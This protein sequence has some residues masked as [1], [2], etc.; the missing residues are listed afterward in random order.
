[1]LKIKHY[2]FAFFVFLLLVFLSNSSFVFALETIY[3]DLTFLNL[4]LITDSSPI[5]HYVSYFFGLG[6]IAAVI[7]ALISMTIGFIQM[8]YPSPET[9][10]DA[11]DRVK[12]SVLGLVLT[13]SAFIILRTINLSLVAPTT[14]PLTAGAGIFYTNGQDLKPAAPS[15]NTS[16]I[17]PGFTNIT[18]R[19]NSG[20]ALLIW[21]FPQ[22]NL[23]GYENTVVD[24]ITCGNTSSLN[25]VASFKVAYEK[26]GIYYC[27]GGC[28]GDFCKGYM[29]QENLV[30]GELPEP[31]KNNI[32]SVLFVN[33]LSK[34]IIYSAI[35]HQQN[36]PT[37]GGICSVPM[38]A[39]KERVCIN[40]SKK[41]D[42][43]TPENENFP[44]SSVSIYQ[45][46]FKTPESS[47]DGIEFYSE[48][49]GWNSGAKAGKNFINKSV[50][51]NFWNSWTINLF[52]NYDNVDRP[53][54]Y[55]KSYTNFRE[56]SGSIRVKGSYVVA[57]YSE[58][59]SYCQVF[60]A[61]V[62]N[63]NEMEFVAK[64]NVL[65]SVF[66]IPTK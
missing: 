18:Y 58:Q 27:L 14:T 29:S 6:I 32:Q 12:G 41:D 59:N 53:E 54:E 30:S 38:G 40:L 60:Y 36:D 10:K 52:F 56:R 63:L 35:F 33:D 62:P 64:K 31:F 42:P 3:P 45:W 15:G 2:K 25:G 17:P 37:R 44:I 46:N 5:E 9:H 20:P 50:I 23:T 66:V 19:C 49:F 61:D 1:M 43:I 47:G 48:P 8:M 24:R 55:K 4:P 65:D 13:L 22:E 7:L 57:I 39:N 28:N 11:V 51:K 26:P 21:K 16:S 34:D